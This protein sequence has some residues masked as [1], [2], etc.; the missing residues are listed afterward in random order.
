M[1]VSMPKVVK[2]V[3]AGASLRAMLYVHEYPGCLQ[4]T[5]LAVD[6][7]VHGCKSPHG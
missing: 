5:L 6:E 4:W 2:S 1:C 3:F 7:A